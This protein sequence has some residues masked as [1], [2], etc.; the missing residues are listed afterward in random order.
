M[1]H[2]PAHLL[3]YQPVVHRI[4][5][6]AGAALVLAPGGGCLPPAPTFGHAPA[7]GTQA[8]PSRSALGAP[9]EAP[10]KK[11]ALGA[12]AEAPRK[13]RALGGPAAPAPSAGASLRQI[14]GDPC[15]AG[16]H[17][18]GHG[19]TARDTQAVCLLRRRGFTGKEIC[20]AYEDLHRVAHGDRRYLADLAAFRAMEIPMTEFAR[21]KASGLSLTSYYN[22]RTIGGHTQRR[23]GYGL[24]IAGISL[25]GVGLSFA[26][27]GLTYMRTSQDVF[28]D[29][30]GSVV[31]LAP[32]GAMGLLGLLL[33]S[34]GMALY[35][36]GA[37]KLKRWLERG[38]LEGASRETLRLHL[39]RRNHATPRP[40]PRLQPTIFPG[41]G[42]LVL[43]LRF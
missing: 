28:A 11:R 10:R 7:L 36:H 43:Q 19:L 27:G 23:V 42:G 25:L 9:A 6:A 18:L 16:L 40:S 22:T 38:L 21:F 37:K 31:F 4:S 3:P 13:K 30:I 12:P 17:S 39:M 5:I 24:S 41:G 20:Q 29:S 26:L 34:V 33:G 1:T 15:I 14:L 8:S 32:G 35:E 2:E